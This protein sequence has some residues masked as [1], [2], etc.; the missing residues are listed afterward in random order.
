ME[1]FS[2]PPPPPRFALSPLP[3]ERS[4][5]INLYLFIYLQDLYRAKTDT[6]GRVKQQSHDPIDPSTVFSTFS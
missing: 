4:P 2:P 1:T 3:V 6:M 5:L